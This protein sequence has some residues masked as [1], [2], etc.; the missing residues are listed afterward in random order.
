MVVFKMTNL[1]LF[2][3]ASARA[4]RDRGIAI[5]ASYPS[6]DWL[7]KAQSL[8]ELIAA[9]EGEVDIEKIYKHIGLPPHANAAGSVFKSKKFR[10][11]GIVEATRLQ[12]RAGVIRRWCLI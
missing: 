6:D 4:L 11:I 5:A 7:K 3:S 2:D 10:C 12:R 9:T 1:P 8:A